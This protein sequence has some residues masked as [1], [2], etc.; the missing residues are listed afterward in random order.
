MPKVILK[1]TQQ[2]QYQIGNRVLPGGTPVEMSDEELKKHKDVFY[3]VVQ[4]A[5]DKPA[6]KAELNL[7]LNGNGKFDKEDSSLAGKVLAKSKKKVK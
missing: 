5:K 6:E 7:D 1:G 3:M 4:E 2:N